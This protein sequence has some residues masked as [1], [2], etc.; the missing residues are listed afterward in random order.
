MGGFNC[1][2]V[3]LVDTEVLTGDSKTDREKNDGSKKRRHDA[4]IMRWNKSEDS[5][6]VITLPTSPVNPK[7]QTT[8]SIQNTHECDT[9]AHAWVTEA[10]AHPFNPSDKSPAGS[11]S[12]SDGTFEGCWLLLLL[13]LRECGLIQQT[14]AE[15]RLHSDM[16]V[17]AHGSQC[18]VS[19]T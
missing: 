12:T 14:S 7:T 8:H 1:Q 10:D 3:S 15:T 13:W 19:L 11:V 6:P 4:W 2:S 5:P 17:Q 9:N 18:D 16:H